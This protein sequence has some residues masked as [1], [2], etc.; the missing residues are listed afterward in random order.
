VWFAELGLPP[1]MNDSFVLTDDDTIAGVRASLPTGLRGT[2]RPG[3][4]WTTWSPA[5][6]SVGWIHLH[7][8]RELAQHCGHAEIL[9]EQV[10]AGR[11]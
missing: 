7:P 4:P 3:C 11:A 8:I 2:R 9:R 6:G 10:L 1:T 5:T